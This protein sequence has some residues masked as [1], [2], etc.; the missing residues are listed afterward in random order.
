MYVDLQVKQFLSGI[1]QTGIFST[2]LS[3][4]PSNV[5]FHKQPLN[6]DMTKEKVAFTN[7][8]NNV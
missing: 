5:K 3:V 6:T 1:K 7:S 4:P 2:N 8:L